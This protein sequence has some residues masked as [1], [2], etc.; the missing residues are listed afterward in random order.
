MFDLLKT[1]MSE[2]Y[3][4]KRAATAKKPYYKVPLFFNGRPIDMNVGN[5]VARVWNSCFKLG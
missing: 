3:F 4:E 2:I 5:H 1:K